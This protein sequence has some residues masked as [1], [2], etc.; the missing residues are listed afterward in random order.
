MPKS[1]LKTTIDTDNF[2]M[3]DDLAKCSGFSKSDLVNLLLSD[4]FNM[5]NRMKLIRDI[6]VDSEFKKFDK[7]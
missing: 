5:T 1:L 7:K 6:L 2:V 4:F 3:L